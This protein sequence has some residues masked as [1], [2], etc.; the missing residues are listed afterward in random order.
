M[1]LSIRVFDTAGKALSVNAAAITKIIAID[2][3]SCE[4]TTAQGVYGCSC[5]AKE[6][7]AVVAAIPAAPAAPSA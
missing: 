7:L 5:S 2:G 4:V 6:V 1:E 3:G